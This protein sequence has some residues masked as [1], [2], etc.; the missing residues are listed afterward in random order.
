MT[1]ENTYEKLLSLFRENPQKYY[2]A[3]VL[4]NST[5]SAALEVMAALSILED[6]GLIERRGISPSAIFKLKEN[7][8]S[9]EPKSDE[10]GLDEFKHIYF[11]A[12]TVFS[13][14]KVQHEAVRQAII[15]S[16]FSIIK[17][18]MAD[19]EAFKDISTPDSIVQN[20]DCGLVI[21]PDTKQV[22]TEVIILMKSTSVE[23]EYGPFCRQAYTISFRFE[24]DVTLHDDKLEVAL[25]FLEAEEEDQFVFDT[26]D[27]QIEEAKPEV[28]TFYNELD[29]D[30]EEN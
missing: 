1:V 19:T 7:F 11:T 28:K 27:P 29:D 4:T 2:S 24:Y 23:E 5:N 26:L 15:D 25:K 12:S 22:F 10:P 20:E 9:E 16:D 13:F 18:T 21:K 8:V 6:N 3:V 30:D 17:S 14:E